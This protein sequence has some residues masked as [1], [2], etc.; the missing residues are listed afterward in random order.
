MEEPYALEEEAGALLGGGCCLNSAWPP[1][2][3]QVCLQAVP[4]IPGI[5]LAGSPRL[6]LLQGQALSSCP[7]SSGARNKKEAF[8]VEH[9]GA[10]FGN[11]AAMGL[12]A[13]HV[14]LGQVH[15]RTALTGWLRQ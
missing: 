1:L 2:T 3:L 11:A 7:A 4:H 14:L 5:C 15:R 13:W 10:C 6:S 12:V 8:D 9:G